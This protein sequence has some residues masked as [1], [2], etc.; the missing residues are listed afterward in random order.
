MSQAAMELFILGPSDVDYN[1]HAFE[2]RER[3]TVYL[4]ELK[5]IFNTEPGTV[6]G[7]MD[8]GVDLE[9]LVYEMDLEEDEI[10]QRITTQIQK[11]CTMAPLF[12]TKIETRF[13]KGTIRDTCFVDVI[14]DSNRYLQ[15]RIT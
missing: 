3:L 15:I 8:K 4:L 13:A 14:I 7:A 1:E 6:I 5:N 9:A 11:Y 2:L 12:T 10:N